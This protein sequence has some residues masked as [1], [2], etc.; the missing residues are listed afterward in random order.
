MK[1]SKMKVE[2]VKVD[3][4]ILDP[5]N[6]RT[7]DDRNIEALKGS[8]TRFGQQKP[9]VV[10]PKNIVIAGNGTLQAAKELDWP[11]IDIVRTELEGVERTAFA[12]ADN[13]TA[14]LANWDTKALAETL[15]AIDESELELESTGFDAVDLSA[16][17]SDWSIDGAISPGE[18]Y[19]IEKEVYLVKVEGVKHEDKDA[20]VHAVNEVASGI[21]AGYNAKAY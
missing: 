17:E 8:L 4:L 2:S 11:T 21:G 12:I 3:K 5:S 15:K 10:S 20:L 6:V 18:E 19:S 16:L 13:R 14:E 1:G 7:H 9:I